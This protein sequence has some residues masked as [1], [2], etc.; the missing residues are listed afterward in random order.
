MT[1]Q[2]VLDWMFSQLPMYQRNG[3][4]AFKKDLTNIVKLTKLLHNPQNEYK[5]IHVGGTNGKGSTTHM[6]ASVLQES[7]YTV[8]LYT[9][10]HLK[11]FRERIKVNGKPASKDFVINFIEK[12]KSFF[13]E[14]QL[15]FF[16]MTVGMAF[17]YFKEQQVDIAVVEVGLGGR[18]DSTNII[19]PILSV[20][21]NISLDHTEMLGN[22]LTSIAFEKAGII[23][24]NVPVIIGEK[25]IE[26]DAVFIQKA[27]QANAK[28]IFA[29]DLMPKHNFTSD[30]KGFYQQKNIR[31]VLV[32]LD[33]LSK[34]FKLTK[35]NSIKG[36]QNTIKNT[37]LSGRWQILEENPKIICDTGHNLAGIKEIA[38]QLETLKKE[39]LH[40]VLGFV[41]D[42][43]VSKIL[44]EFPEDAYYYFAEPD[45][46][47]KMLLEDLKKQVRKPNVQ[48]FST[49]SEAFEKARK[50]ANK[51]DVI[52]V[53][54]STFVVAEI[55]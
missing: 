26:T 41:N 46:P 52:F 17:Q 55:L 33:E 27:K 35:K 53:G 13:E 44:D 39:K 21:T 6:L 3:K 29:E 48:Y 14:N 40:L 34:T 18:L 36:L 37:S 22:T 4:S 23:K 45:I 16:E 7:G 24:K 49:I 20:I 1:Y 15:S 30:L 32:T 42:K 5:T 2:E 51:E 47:R 11:D 12:H 28:I 25:H 9:S 38:K 8:G 10:P 43:E 31:T 50:K 54:G 19:N